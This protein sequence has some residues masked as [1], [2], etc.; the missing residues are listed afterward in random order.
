MGTLSARLPNPQLKAGM[1]KPES[2]SSWVWVGG[3]TV[4][5]SALWELVR[6]P[7]EA[8]EREGRALSP[9]GEAGGAFWSLLGRR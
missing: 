5:H 2:L 7:L 8:R 6:H 1:R 9:C 4:H 3:L